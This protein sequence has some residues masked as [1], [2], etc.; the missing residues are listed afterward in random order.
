MRIFKVSPY[1]KYVSLDIHVFENITHWTQE[2]QK[3][4]SRRVIKQ[5]RRYFKWL[6]NED[7]MMDSLL[8]IQKA[9]KRYGK[10][11]TPENVYGYIRKELGRKSIIK[12][13]VV[14]AQALTKNKPLLICKQATCVDQIDAVFNRLERND[15]EVDLEIEESDYNLETIVLMTDLKEI[16]PTDMYTI[17]ERK[18][19]NE[20]LLQRKE[21]SI[22]REA[23]KIIKREYYAE[24]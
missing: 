6:E 8:A 9:Y 11:L 7:A 20:E 15:F 4:C 5:T 19:V 3:E 10:T 23:L 21:Q 2:E 24:L 17:F 16:L 1:T 12:Q 22:Y 13:R 14:N 18:F